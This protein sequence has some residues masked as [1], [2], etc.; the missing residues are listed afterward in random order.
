[1]L[2]GLDDLHEGLP[3]PLYQLQVGRRIFD[4]GADHDVECHDEPVL[5]GIRAATFDRD[6]KTVGKAPFTPAWAGEI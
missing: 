4:P 1:M 6:R 2:Y 5:V 3:C